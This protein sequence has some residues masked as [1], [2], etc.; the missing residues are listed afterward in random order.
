MEAH[1]KQQRVN[2]LDKVS[3]PDLG[4]LDW[5]IQLEESGLWRRATK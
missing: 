4:K 3:K 1:E 2:P 5:G